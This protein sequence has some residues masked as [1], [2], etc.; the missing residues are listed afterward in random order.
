M[1]HVSSFNNG[2]KTQT[3]RFLQSCGG[4]EMGRFPDDFKDFKLEQV[5]Q[6]LFRSWSIETSSMWT[7]DNPARGQCSVTALAINDL[8]GGEILKTLLPEGWHF[9]NRIDGQRYD[10]TDSQFDGPIDYMDPPSNR[11]EA[12]LDTSPHQYGV[13]KQ[14]LLRRLGEMESSQGT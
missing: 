11:D 7:L 3:T 9:Y 2:C 5:R 12:M 13:L 14:N 4:G 10:F 6:A 8:F 1:L